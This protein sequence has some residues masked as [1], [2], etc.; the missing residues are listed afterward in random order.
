MRRY[1]IAVYQARLEGAALIGWREWRAAT[2]EDIVFPG[3][4]SA[5]DIA[6]AVTALLLTWVGFLVSKHTVNAALAKVRETSKNYGVVYPPDA[7]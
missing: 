4:V 7:I 6:F 1:G 2:I 5:W 3:E